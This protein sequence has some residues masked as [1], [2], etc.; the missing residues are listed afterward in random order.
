MLNFFL[1]R[2]AYKSYFKL[3]SLATFCRPGN[4]EMQEDHKFKA[5]L[6]DMM[7]P[8]P[9]KKKKVKLKI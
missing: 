5:Y 4:L 9:K 2:K 1:S 7:I 6:K 3:G 8:F